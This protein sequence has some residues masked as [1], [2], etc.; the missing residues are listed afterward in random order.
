MEKVLEKSNL[1]YVL[2]TVE[3]DMRCYLKSLHEI[4]CYEI[5]ADIEKASKARSK[6]IINM[7]LDNYRMDMKEQALDFFVVPVLIEYNLIK[8]D[9]EN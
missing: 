4:G 3:N 6:K 7:L 2:A 9:E 5:T 8:V 1:V